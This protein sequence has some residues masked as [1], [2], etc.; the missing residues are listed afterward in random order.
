MI[1]DKTNLDAWY[2]HAAQAEGF[3]GAE[4]KAQRGKA[5]LMQEQQRAMLQIREEKYDQF[6]LRLQSMPLPRTDQFETDVQR[7]VEHVA[8]ELGVEVSI[9]MGQLAELIQTGLEP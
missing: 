3:I 4:L 7:I 8:G 2:R 1:E 9:N 6:W 5:F